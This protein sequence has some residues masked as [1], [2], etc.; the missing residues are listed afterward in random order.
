M[1]V[2]GWW[3][4][5]LGVG[6]GSWVMTVG[7]DITATLAVHLATRFSCSLNLVAGVLGLENSEVCY[8]CCLCRR[9]LKVRIHYK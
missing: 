7:S 8:F 2:A 9:F 4:R 3:L 5:N 1:E 6:K